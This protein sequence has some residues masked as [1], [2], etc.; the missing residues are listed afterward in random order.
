[1]LW[2]V[3]GVLIGALPCAGQAQAQQHAV[4]QM[5]PAA[6]TPEACDPLKRLSI[7]E[8]TIES[9]EVVD[10][11]SF[12]PPASLYAIHK[13]PKFCRVAAVTKPAVQF[14]VWLPLEKWTGRIEAVGNGGMAGE[15]SYGAMANAL[16]RGN[17]ARSPWHRS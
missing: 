10:A 8:T 5:R 9:A 17:A 7:E 3:G 14:E 15:I 1:M 16:R 4:R 2:V 11:G 13:L 6:G 12:T